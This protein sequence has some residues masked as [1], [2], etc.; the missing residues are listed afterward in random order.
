MWYWHKIWQIDQWNR[1]QSLET[2]STDQLMFDR[3]TKALPC[4]KESFSINDGGIPGYSC[5]KNKIK[6][7]TP[8]PTSYHISSNR[9]NGRI[10]SWFRDMQCFLRQES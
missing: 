3:G 9:K 2:D 4:R 8:T 7:R 5:E 6:K 1:T 10:S